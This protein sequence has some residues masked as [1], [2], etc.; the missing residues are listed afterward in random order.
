VA[1][2][3]AVEG[4][5]G[6][7]KTTVI[8]MMMDDLR[9]SGFKVETVDIETI[10]HAPTL[11]AITETYP[12]DHPVRSILFWALRLEQYDAIQKMRESAD[13]IFADRFWGTTLAFDV[14]GNGAP[15]QLLDW[16][17][18][19]IQRQPDI[20]LLF[21]VP[22]EVVMWRKKGKTMRDTGF[23]RRVERGYQELADTLSWVRVDATRAPTEVKERCLQVVLSKL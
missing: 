5:P 4:L 3:V 18:R 6:S 10:G 17:G 21:E 9:G 11:R 16:L 19:Y 15:R 13:V 23:A 20:T 22:L 8:Q 14:Y 7:G 12:L 2:T 1:L